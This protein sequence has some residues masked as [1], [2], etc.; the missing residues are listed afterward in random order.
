[1][2]PVNLRF[3][4]FV[5][6]FV[7]N[8][9]SVAIMAVAAKVSRIDPINVHFVY[10][11][12]KQHKPFELYKFIAIKSAILANW[13]CKVY[14]WYYFEPI[15]RY[16][17]LIKKNLVLVRV[18]PPSSIYG[19][20]VSHYAHQADIIRLLVLIRYGGIYLDIDTIS[21]RPMRG[22]LGEGVVLARQDSHGLC[23]AT[24]VAK[25]NAPFLRRWL[26][27]YRTFNATGYNGDKTWD[28]HSVRV[29]F[30]LAK[31]YPKEVTILPS[32]AFF[33]FSFSQ[34]GHEFLRGNDRLIYE[35]LIKKAYS[36]HLWE[37]KT[38]RLLPNNLHDI[39][40]RPTT[41]Y[42]L[43]CKII[44]SSSIGTASEGTLLPT[45]PNLTKEYAEIH[46]ILL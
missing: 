3:G 41:L 26:A 45:Y 43:V 11:L 21:F 1:M 12:K 46:Y 44:L 22:L 38:A 18:V 6:A 35:D 4:A 36:V 34:I 25:Q 37:T 17:E 23:N 9:M 13:P 5:E 32:S 2:G 14:F 28:Y 20:P 7:A 8:T 31:R 10:G 30:M 29:P 40:L 33:Y 16:W 19:R 15:G 27:T 42:R 24:I 39:L